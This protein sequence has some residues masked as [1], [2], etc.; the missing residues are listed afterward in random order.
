MSPLRVGGPGA[1]RLACVALASFLWACTPTVD[2]GAFS[3]DPDSLR[4]TARLGEAAPSVGEVTLTSNGGEVFVAL[5]YARDSGPIREASLLISGSQGQLRVAPRRPDDLGVGLHSGSIRLIPCADRSCTSKLGGGVRTISVLYEVESDVEPGDVT[6]SPP[7]LSFSMTQGDV[8]PPGQT[9]ALAS[10]SGRSVTWQHSVIDPSGGQWLTVSAADTFR[11]P[12]SLVVDVS[13]TLAAGT[14]SATLRISDRSTHT[15]VPVTFTVA[16]APLRASPASALFT[17]SS[18]SPDPQLSQLITLAD[19]GTPLSWTATASV[20]WLRVTPES[21]TTGAGAQLTLSLLPDKVDDIGANGTYSATVILSYSGASISAKTLRLPVTLNVDLQWVD[22]VAPYVAISGRAEE[23]ILRGSGF[24]GRTSQPVFF[25][26]TPASKVT[27]VSDTELRV[28]HPALAAGRYAVRVGA[29]FPVDT[30]RASLAVVDAQHYGASRF[31]ALGYSKTLVHDAERRALFASMD[32]GVARYAYDSVA[33]RWS[34]RFVPLPAASAFALTP[35]GTALLVVTDDTFLGLDPVSLETV[36]TVP[37]SF[38]T[39]MYSDPKIQFANNGKALI[40]DGDLNLYLFDLAT[41]ELTPH[42][43]HKASWLTASGD[44][45]RILVSDG[46]RGHLFDASSGTFVE[47][48]TAR[49]ALALDRTGGR[50]LFG[51]AGVY[52]AD[53]T[54]LGRLQLDPLGPLTSR[55]LSPDGRRAYVE[56]IDGLYTY[57]LSGPPQ[58]DGT[59]PLLGTPLPFKIEDVIHVVTVSADGNTLFLA[60]DDSIFVQPVP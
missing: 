26:T 49:P 36:W 19:T 5:E 9:I 59:Y 23:V 45:S 14:Y 48:F 16:P 42:Q 4:F 38:R 13:P 56:Q 22:F 25:D 30:S 18:E 57:D 20:P 1:F 29:V 17:L 7:R 58:A 15:D 34:S 31:P 6:A 44:G 21:G 40:A 3:T 32:S 43:G 50:G 10:Q 28:T 52:D 54:F 51:A 53:F 12:S 47:T 41:R 60:G 11:Y 33:D 24:N 35:D 39:A 2:S 37:V 8:A 55:A 46:L 27:R